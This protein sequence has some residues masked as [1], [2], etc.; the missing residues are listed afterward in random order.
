M[1]D[2]TEQGKLFM[3]YQELQEIMK[4]H[5]DIDGLLKQLSLK[6]Q[7]SQNDLEK[8]ES[9]SIS[10]LESCDRLEEAFSPRTSKCCCS[11]D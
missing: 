7:A 2:R 6:E 10:I 8:L 3:I 9:S 4:H 5:V 11:C 1:S